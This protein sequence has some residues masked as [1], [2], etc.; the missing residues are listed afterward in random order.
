MLIDADYSQIE[1]R[2]LAHISGDRAF[3]QAFNSGRDIHTQTASEIFHVAPEH[4]T[5]EMR[6]NAKAVNFGIV[7]GIGDYSL[8]VDI[9]TSRAQAAAYIERYFESYP[10]VR[11]YLERVKVEAK[12]DGYVTTLFGRRRYIPELSATK[13]PTVAF[14]ERIAMNT[15][16]Q[17]TA[18]DIIK[19]AMVNTDRRLEK[20][21][22]Q[23]RL[24]MQ[25][26]DELIIECP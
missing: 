18:A 20:E 11:D 16:I 3:T 9:G 12:R 17:G 14:G 7:Y 25:V 5:P 13:K 19:L 24:I 1:L 23:A 21:I 4:V 15:P 26:H 2:L 22:P 8:S 6:K 10:T